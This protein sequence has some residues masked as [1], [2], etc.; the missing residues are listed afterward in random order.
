MHHIAIP[1]ASRSFQSCSTTHCVPKSFFVRRHRVKTHPDVVSLPSC[2][3]H[4]ATQGRLAALLRHCRKWHLIG[5]NNVNRHLFPHS[6]SRFVKVV[7]MIVS[8]RR[9]FFVRRHRSKATPRVASHPLGCEH[10]PFRNPPEAT[11][12]KSDCAT[13]SNGSHFFSQWFETYNN[14]ML[15]GVKR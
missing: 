7:L 1:R 4:G 15:A 13:S 8:C 2:G 5:K 6:I 9:A 11:P 3:L 10:G 12:K 14:V